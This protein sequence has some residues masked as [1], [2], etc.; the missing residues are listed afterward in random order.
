MELNSRSVNVSRNKI[1]LKIPYQ[2]ADGKKYWILNKNDFKTERSK[3]GALKMRLRF[4]GL[5]YCVV[6]TP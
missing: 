3:L 1:N 5:N 6:V 4:S 2:H